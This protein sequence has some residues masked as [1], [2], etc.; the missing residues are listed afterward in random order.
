MKPNVKDKINIITRKDFIN[1]PYLLLATLL[2]LTIGITYLFYQ[3][4]INKDTLRF[5]NEVDHIQTALDNRI[6]L[7]IALLKSGRGYIQSKE[8]VSRPDFAHFVESL[9]LE[10]NYVGGQGIGYTKLFSSEERESLIVHM[11]E[12]EGIEDFNI[13]PNAES[14]LQQAVI[15]LEPLTPMN[16]KA[17]GFDM[18]T[19]TNRR[20]AIERA[21]DTGKASASAKVTLLQE[22]ENDKQA[23]FVIYLPV[24]KN[25][26]TPLTTIQRQRTLQGFVYSPFRTQSLLT[27]VQNS[28][29]TKTIAVQI[30]DGGPTH[31]NLMAQTI[32]TSQNDFMPWIRSDFKESKNLNVAGRQWLINYKTLPAFDSQS[33]AGWTPYI[34]F[35]GLI[36]SFSVFGLTLWE[37]L[38]R[39]KLQT[40]A[41]ELFE[42]EKQKRKLLITEQ[43]AREAA[44]LANTAKD[45]F[46]SVVSHELRTPLNSIAGW[47]RIL[48][49]NHLTDEKR[50]M[51]L[52]KIERNLRQQTVL[53]DDLINYS[54]MIVEKTELEVEP[55][56]VSE[57]FEEAY[58]NIKKEAAEKH[59]EIH[60]DNRLNGSVILCNRESIKTVFNNL[61]ANAVKFTPDGGKVE[62]ELF[63]DDNEI[64]L[65]I[66]DSGIGIEP[67]F[68]PHIFDSFSQADSSIT[69]QYGGLGLGLAISKHIIKL[70]NGTI[71]A[72]SKGEGKGSV[73]TIKIPL[74]GSEKERTS[75]N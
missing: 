34:F 48:Q 28:T 55:I 15:F 56:V 1:L 75:K 13:F 38:S 18:S 52:E 17:I 2:I 53:V 42:S 25:G 35:C 33:S 31:E 47:T 49:T 29:N 6:G 61:L 73:F 8:N 59:I 4:S 26:L 58:Q 16:R 65:I 63:K 24:Y 12:H 71:E 67:K 43:E 20:A 30:F 45:E 22:T 36:F 66:K 14:D 46:I 51:A 50:Q 19:E 68:L 62:T 54:K 10:K 39:K 64:E 11:R 60:K 27:E 5:N 69:R 23:G 21:R 44:E 32:D 40:V 74:N 70:H 41:G 7:Y 57:V 3:N 37:S 72:H 9:E